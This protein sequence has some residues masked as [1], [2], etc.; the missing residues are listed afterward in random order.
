MGTYSK[1]SPVARAWHISQIAALSIGGHV[2]AVIHSINHE[3]ASAGEFFGQTR[4]GRD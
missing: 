3:D 2:S 1:W 4:P